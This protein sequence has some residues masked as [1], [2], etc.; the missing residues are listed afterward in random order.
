MSIRTDKVASAIRHALAEVLLTG[1]RDPSFAFCT[2]TGVQVTADLRSAT[3]TVS[4][5]AKAPEQI[6]KDLQ[7]AAGFFRT[8]LGQT[9]YLKH[10]PEIHFVLDQSSELNLKIS[11]IMK[12]H[13][14]TPD[15]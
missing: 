2:I 12:G 7:D 8:R 9:M 11:R 14:E 1:S 3:V 15:R 13:H 4:T 6:L 5:L 10:V